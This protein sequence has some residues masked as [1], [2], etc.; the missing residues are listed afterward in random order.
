MKLNGFVG[1]GSGKLGASVFAISGGEQIVRQYNPQVANPNTDAQMQQ[2]AKL[3]LMSQ[4]AAVFGPALAFK[5][6]GLVSA[7]NQFVSKNIGQ[8]VFEDGNATIDLITL[9]LTPGN[10][11]L[12]GISITAGQ[13]GQNQIE[14]AAMA[15][16]GVKRVVYVITHIDSENKVSV[17]NVRLVSIGGVN[18]TFP[19]NFS[20][21][22]GSDFVLAYGIIDANAGATALYENF[23][24]DEND[25]VATL[26]YIKSNTA[27]GFI[28]TETSGVKASE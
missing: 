26:A 22:A 14:L 16:E 17:N 3:K 10:T 13:G 12:P 28:Y 19:T 25:M 24:A 6:K 21:E 7:R 27:A 9:Q 1:K 20:L 2:R 4:L 18:N 5:K 8:A 15:P 11:A 23:V